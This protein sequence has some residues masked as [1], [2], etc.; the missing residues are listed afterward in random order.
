M[1]CWQRNPRE[2]AMT[3]LAEWRDFYLM[4]GT[5]S[6]VIVGATF[7]VAS[8]ASE[9]G[10]K[11]TTGLRGFIT[12]TAVHLSSVLIGSAILAIPMLTPH[13]LAL[14]LGAGGIGGVIYGFVIVTRIRTLK[15]DAADWSFYAILPILT[16]FA[17]AV[18]AALAGKEVE[19]ALEI[20]AGSFIAL[21]IIGMRNAWDMATFMITHDKT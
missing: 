14:L 12:P 4:I 7:I 15:L 17:I 16:Y 10:E 1:A 5:A 8:L 9:M 3:T 20:L 13:M 18:A 19:E 2:T 6:G 11:R 21:L